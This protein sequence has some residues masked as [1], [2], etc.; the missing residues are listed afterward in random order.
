LL[1]DGTGNGE[2][3]TRPLDRRELEG[4]GEAHDA[5]N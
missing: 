2:R 5:V 3:S 1:E 4:I